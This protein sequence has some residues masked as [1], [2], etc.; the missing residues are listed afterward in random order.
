M[1]FLADSHC[2]FFIQKTDGY[3]P[4]FIVTQMTTHTG[5]GTLV[6]CLP[7]GEKNMEM[8]VEILFLR[9]RCVTL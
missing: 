2:C 8:I 9:D 4:A 6:N 7:A 5:G 1:T 3:V